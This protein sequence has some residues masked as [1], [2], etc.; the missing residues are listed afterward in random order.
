[1]PVKVKAADDQ[2][3]TV[4][5]QGIID[6]MWQEEGGWVLLDYKSNHIN[7]Q[8]TSE[9]IQN[10]QAQIEL[11]AQAIREIWQEP[12]KAAYLY[13]FHTERAIEMKITE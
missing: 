6:C 11:Y 8:N 3:C 9:F 5:V 1:M 13:L 2:E 10:Y 4:L 12:L 7:R